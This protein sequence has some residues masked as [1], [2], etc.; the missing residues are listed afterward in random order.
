MMM[1]SVLHRDEE[2]G[3]WCVEGPVAVRDVDMFNVVETD[4]TAKRTY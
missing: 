2:E 1:M 3:R 4:Q